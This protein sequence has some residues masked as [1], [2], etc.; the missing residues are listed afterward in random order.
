MVRQSESISLSKVLIGIK[1][2]D[3]QELSKP[4]G[5]FETLWAVARER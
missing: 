1:Y 5:D 4:I 2:A 3:F